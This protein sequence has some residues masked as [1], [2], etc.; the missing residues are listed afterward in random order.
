[1]QKPTPAKDND[2][3]FAAIEQVS[4]TIFDRLGAIEKPD[5]ALPDDA[6]HA[7]GQVQNPPSPETTADARP[8]PT[9]PSEIPAPSE[10]PKHDWTAENETV[11]QD[12]L[13]ILLR[14]ATSLGQLD[15]SDLERAIAAAHSKKIGPE[16]ARRLSKLPDGIDLLKGKSSACSEE[17]MMAAIRGV[18]TD[19]KRDFNL[20]SLPQLLPQ[21]K[22]SDAIE[23]PVEAAPAEDLDMLQKVRHKIVLLF[24]KDFVL[25][26]NAAFWGAMGLYVLLEPLFSLALFGNGLFILIA[27][28]FV[29]APETLADLVSDAW[30][31]C[32]KW[33][34]RGA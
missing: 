32:T 34:R 24:R 27:V 22:Q 31:F 28:C 20:S 19:Q 15:K 14:R 25:A 1:M 18:I 17:A 8:A 23:E 12:L 30:K 29:F 9:R 33:A 21:Y 16:A 7:G 2:T 26:A 10:P 3:R 6:S 5:A 13:E 4:D 11:A